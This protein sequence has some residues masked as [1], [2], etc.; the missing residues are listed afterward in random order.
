MLLALLLVL[1]LTPAASA[2]EDAF[3]GRIAY[4]TP[5]GQLATVDSDGGEPVLLSQVGPQYRFPAFA[6]N[7]SRLA[8]IAFDEAGG[9]IRV[10]AGRDSAQVYQSA[11]E[12][13]I[14]LSWSPDSER[15]SFIAADAQAGLAFYVAAG[16]VAPGYGANGAP[17]TSRRWASG[18]PFYWTWSAD[19]NAVLVHAGGTGE[20]ARLAFLD[21]PADAQPGSDSGGENID[22]PGFFQAPGIS[23]SGRFIAY[24]AVGAGGE[25]EVV[26]TSSPRV[27][28]PVVRRSFDHEGF[29]V[30]SWSPVADL[31][32]VM[33]PRRPS[34][35]WFG[36]V[37][38][39][40]AEDG[41]LQTV[42]DET[43]LAFFWSPDGAKLAVLSP[44]AESD[45]RQ[46]ADVQPGSRPGR[47]ARVQQSPI[48]LELRVFY[49]AGDRPGRSETLTSFTP[50]QT[51]ATQFLPFFDQYALSHRIWSPESDGVVLPMVAIDGISRVVHVSLDGTQRELARGD[52]P[53]WNVR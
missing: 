16:Y 53:F 43:A 5:L 26:V 37:R 18:S 35:H 19:S 3:A 4:V 7:G 25:R 8:A 17:W 39:L 6:P 51:F 22:R 34:P 20:G 52:M 38:V 27:A 33:S 2:Q 32:A 11:T 13:P 10:F 30:M 45:V 46:V 41:L 21:V 23:P 24:A 47:P 48:R 36:P 49:L 28:G 44:L 50:S 14:Y 42:V 12:A 1:A 15:L 40:D 9:S 29:A 31:L